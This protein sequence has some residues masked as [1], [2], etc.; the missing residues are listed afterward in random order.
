MIL[1]QKYIASDGI[2]QEQVTA[3]VSHK[4]S[5]PATRWPTIE[6]EAFGI[7]FG[8]VRKLEYLLMC[9]SFVVKTDDRNFV[10]METSLVAKIIR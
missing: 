1:Y 5:G 9:K 7:Y 3:I 6:Q 4:F 10:W 8:V 2:L